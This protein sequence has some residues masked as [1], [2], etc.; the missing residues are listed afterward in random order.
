LLF[1]LRSILGSSLGERAIA[2]DME[3]MV[4]RMEREIAEL[5]RAGS[6]RTSEINDLPSTERSQIETGT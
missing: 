4:P 1:W 2:A 3:A 6:K 5:G